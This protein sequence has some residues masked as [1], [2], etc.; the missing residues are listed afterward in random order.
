M[1]DSQRKAIHAKESHK[2]RHGDPIK[3]DDYVHFSGWGLAK[4][5]SLDRDFLNDPK[6]TVNTKTYK[7]QEFSFGKRSAHPHEIKYVSDADAKK[8]IARQ[9]ELRNRD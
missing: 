5:H 4:V 3:K 7:G 6:F 8:H 1:K 2:D 9:I